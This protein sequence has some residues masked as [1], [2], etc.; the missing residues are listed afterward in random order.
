MHDMQVLN[1]MTLN[2][3]LVYHK[4]LSVQSAVYFNH[5]SIEVIMKL[6]II[7]YLSAT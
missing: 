3:I 2:Y 4:C 7:K 5:I 1:I 6:Y